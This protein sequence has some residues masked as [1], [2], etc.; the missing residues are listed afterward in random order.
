MTLKE[1]IASHIVHDADLIRVTI[2]KDVDT[3]KHLR[4]RHMYDDDVLD[5]EV[6]HIEYDRNGGWKVWVRA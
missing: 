5:S 3:V 4:E 2:H 1:L 6:K